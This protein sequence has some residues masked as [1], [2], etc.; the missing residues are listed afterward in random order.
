MKPLCRLM[1]AMLPILAC[2]ALMAGTTEGLAQ[3]GGAPAASAPVAAAS[4]VPAAVPAPPKIDTG[5]TT[6]VL[7]STA[8][9]L[10]MTAP[11]LA[12]FYGGMVRGKNALGTIMQSFIILCLISVQWVLLGY[13]LAFGP[14]KGHLIGGLEWLGLNGVGLEPNA[15]YAATI[16]HQA[17]M[18]F[19]MMFAV[20]TP[21]LITGAFAERMKFSS[22]LVFT[23]LWSTLIYDPLA[24]WV[25]AVGGW[26]RNMGALDFAGGTVVHIS[27]GASALACAFVLRKR[28]GYGKEH[29]VPHNLPMTVLGASL[30]WFGWFG[31][32]AG[33]AVASGALA[34]S[35]FVVTHVAASAAALAWMAVE[36]IYRGKPTVLGAASGAVAGLVAI[37]PA[38]GFVG[39]LSA[40]MIG[41]VAGGL[42]YLAVVWK[43]KCGYDDALDVVG[44]HGVGGIWGALATGL[45]AS[46][47]I[48]AAGADGLFYG[49]PAQFGIQ[50]VTVLISAGFAFVGTVAILKLIGM[51]MPLCVKE[52]EERMGLDLS[53]HD[54]RA[55]S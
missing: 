55:Y 4:E 41:L 37:T 38:S 34:T 23:L 45:F 24:H 7:V 8:L 29:M 39:P 12:L 30:L 26:M 21:A 53:Q 10:A 52:E 3:E 32:N 11:G 15:D 33:S 22:F 28:L 17:F 40:V 50:A 42:C 18:I 9:V 35:A 14:D 13:S 43:A 51:M 25:W 54:E 27:S 31:F 47:A 19:Q 44:I 6:W 48:N 46:K 5:D 1:T 2:L 20:I 16:P 36:W 49:N